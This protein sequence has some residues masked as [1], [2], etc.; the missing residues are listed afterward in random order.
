M[1]LSVALL[2]LSIITCVSIPIDDLQAHEWNL[3]EGF[4]KQQSGRE[5]LKAEENY[6]TRTKQNYRTLEL[7]HRN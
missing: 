3:V 6:K 2:V 1:D 7:Q 5:F 4:R